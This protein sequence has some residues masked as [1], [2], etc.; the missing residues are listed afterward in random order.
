MEGV[1]RTPQELER[2]G[3][4]MVCFLGLANA[5]GAVISL[6]TGSIGYSKPHRTRIAGVLTL[7]LIVF[8]AYMAVFLPIGYW[9]GRRIFERSCVWFTEDRPPTSREQA[10]ALQLAWREAALSFAAWLGAAAVFGTMHLFQDGGLVATRTALNIVMGGIATSTAAYLLVER[11]L[12]P[13]V[14]VALA[15]GPPARPHALGI[16]PRLLL[17]W[18]WGSAIPM[19]ILVLT[20]LG[21]PVG[22][23]P[24]AGGI[25]FL[26]VSGLG[27]GAFVTYV[28][29]HSLADG[30]DPIRAA[31]GRVQAGDLDTEIQVDD[32]GEVGQLQNGFNR[33]VAGL[34]ERRQL[35]DLFGRHVGADVA[36]LALEQG[37]ALG[38]ERREVSVLFVD[39]IGSTELSQSRAPE[40]V[41]DTLNAFFDAVVRTVGAEGGWVNKFEGDGALCVFGAPVAQSDHAARALRAARTLR[42]ELLALAASNPGFDAAIGVSAG[43]VV[44]GNVGTEDRY[45]YTVIGDPVNEAARLTDEAKRQP[46]RVLAGE[47]AVRIAGDEASRWSRAGTVLLRGRS[48]PTTVYA[49]S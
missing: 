24:S 37:A 15:S 32:G 3:L 20:L 44:A 35:Q 13:F 2:I 26:V 10:A 34:R 46:G 28:V 11:A 41:V 5:D 42:Q 8:A 14:A 36:R 47:S 21:P 6:I 48:A 40:Q 18:A 22:R 49:P 30:L 39:L 23:V 9:I 31:L 16:R 29:A 12:R 17:A 38:G 33:M 1:P 43:D 4:K 19:L 27:A 45:E 25:L 7:D